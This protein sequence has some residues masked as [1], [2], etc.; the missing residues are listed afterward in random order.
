MEELIFSLNVTLPVFL[1]M[2]IGYFLNKINIVDVEFA[3]KINKFVFVALLPVLLFKDLSKSDFYTIWDTKYLIY[4][5]LATLFSVVI[6]WIASIFLKDKT[7]QGEF[8]QAGYRSSAA[9]LAYV[10]VQNIYGE[11]KYVAIMMIGA[12]PL[13]NIA[14]VFILMLLKPK[15]N[16]IDLKVLKSA[17]I[18]VVKNPMIIGIVL[19]ITWSLLKIPQPEIMKKTLSSFSGAA[20]PLGLIALG[21]LFDIKSVL[22][23]IVPTITSSLFKLIFLVLIFLPIAIVLG[24][25]DEKLVAVLG[26]LG[27]P[28]TPVCFTMARGFGHKGVLSSGVVMF[29]TLFS[30]LTLTFFLYILKIMGLI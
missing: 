16:K 4:C 19:G 6:L 25:R 8:I 11:G 7:I 10:F 30:A 13:Y 5:F 18:G 28:A 17:V 27:S 14:A 26:M 9:L 24:F 2:L 1:L 29:T 15:R 20:T 12:V 3:N 22:S 23:K 21:A